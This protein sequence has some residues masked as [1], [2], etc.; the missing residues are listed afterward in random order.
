MRFKRKSKNHIQLE[1]IA[2]TDIIMNLFLFFVISFG[3]TSS[4]ASKHSESPLQVDLPTVQ[5]G[6]R[7]SAEQTIDIQITKDGNILWNNRG[8]SLKELREKLAK[9]NK[10]R[11]VA[12]RADKNASIQSLTSV[13]ELVRDVGLTNVALQTEISARPADQSGR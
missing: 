8:A 1:N 7:I 4:L 12:I 5:K 11:P 2:L 9:E 13:L 10:S 6:D 3:V